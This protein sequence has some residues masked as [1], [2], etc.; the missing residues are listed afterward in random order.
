MRPASSLTELKGVGDR[1]AARLAGLG[2]RQIGDLLLH[3]PARYEDRTRATALARLI[4]GRE[5]LI[6]AEIVAAEVSF[7]GRRS[8]KVQLSDKTGWLT[9]R[10]FHFSRAQRDALQP[11]A[12]VQAFGNVA[13]RAGGLEMAHPEY[14]VADQPFGPPVPELTPVYPTTRGIGQRSLRRLARAAIAGVADDAADWPLAALDYLHSPPAD[15]TSA[16]LEAR[17]QSI[18]RDELTAYFLIMQLRARTR[19]SETTL[20]LPSDQQLG[21]ALLKRL[22]FVLT[23]A[24]KRALTEVLNDLGSTQ[25]ML[26]LIQGDVGS[27]KTVIAAFAAVRAAE[28]GAQTA[29]MAPTEILAVQHYLNFSDWLSPLGIEVALLTGSHSAREKRA[30]LAALAA[31]Q[32]LVVVGT[33][34]LFQDGVKFAELGLTIIDEQHRFGVHQRMALRDKGRLPHQLILTA[35]PIPR[36]LTMALYADMDVSIIDELPAGRQPITTAVVSNDRRDDVIERIRSALAA[37]DRKSVV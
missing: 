31:G 5:A 20:A 21:R 3:L 11:G 2:L 37:G 25:P 35:T 7:G 13:L 32:T 12:F 34:A 29:V 30:R 36:T 4:A 28:H 22:G 26:R 16:T 10:F 27:G 14:K 18:A 6:Q 8:L 24:Q 9:L 17:Q 33:H 19:A 1:L 15:A 23:G